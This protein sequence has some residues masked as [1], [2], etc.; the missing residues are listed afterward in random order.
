MNNYPIILTHISS[1]AQGK[2]FVTPKYI[3]TKNE[4]KIELY[5]RYCPHRKYPIADLGTQVD[6]LK[7]NFHGLEWDQKCKPINH[8]YNIRNFGSA[9]VDKTGLVFANFKLPNHKWV[10]DLNKET[11]LMYSHSCNGSSAGSWLWMMEI[12][13]DLLHIR[14]GPDSIH[15]DLGEDIDLE[16][17][18]MHNGDDWILQTCNTGWWLFVYPF[19]F[20]E[21]SPGCLSI[22]YTV[23]NNDNKEF[24]FDWMTQFYYDPTVSEIKRKEFETL[25]VVFKQDVAAIEKQQG[26]YFPLRRTKNRLEE[27]C[28]HFGKWVEKN[29]KLAPM[30]E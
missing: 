4:S 9:T 6:Q 23:P 3:I 25:E 27:H 13:A 19:T 8:H 18:E 21:W 28:I 16:A 30:T 7:C 11:N 29:I 10:D 17:V 26:P 14:K 15:P 1:L 2:K 20:I 22:N 24:G 12:Q 5:S